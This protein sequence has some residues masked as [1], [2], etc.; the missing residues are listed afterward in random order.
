MHTQFRANFALYDHNINFH[1]CWW[2]NFLV[3]NKY[4]FVSQIFKKETLLVEETIYILSI[5]TTLYLK[6]STDLT[7]TIAPSYMGPSTAS[8][9]LSPSVSGSAS[10]T[11]STSPPV[12]ASVSLSSRE[13]EELFTTTIKVN[14]ILNNSPDYFKNTS[15]SVEFSKTTMSNSQ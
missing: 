11:P 13:S 6:N 7:R 2:H 12:S 3:E 8:P 15:P 4:D 9:S 1:D 14:G 10:V 5:L